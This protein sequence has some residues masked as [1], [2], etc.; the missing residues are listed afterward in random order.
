[1]IFN[2]QHGRCPEE[3]GKIKICAK[4]EG[5]HTDNVQLA[6]IG[7]LWPLCTVEQRIVICDG[8]VKSDSAPLRLRE[9]QQKFPDVE[10][11]ARSA[12]HYWLINSELWLRY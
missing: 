4:S 6:C 2:H 12:N 7:T 10:I 11:S 1:M 9:F 8:Y 3:R 5:E